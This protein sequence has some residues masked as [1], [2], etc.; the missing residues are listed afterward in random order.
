MSIFLGKTSVK[1]FDDCSM[2]KL[3][4][5][6]SNTGILSLPGKTPT[7]TVHLSV[8]HVSRV[9]ASNKTFCLGYILLSLCEYY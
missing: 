2:L 1:N 3:N 9:P 6:F 8:K 5:V 7:V 4:I